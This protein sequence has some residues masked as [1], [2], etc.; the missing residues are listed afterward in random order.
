MFIYLTMIAL[1]AVAILSVRAFQ[2]SNRNMDHS[3]LD[4]P[5]EVRAEIRAEP[6]G[7]KSAIWLID[8]ILP[9]EFYSKEN[10]ER[11]FRYFS[12]KHPDIKE[13]INL[14]VY[15]DVKNYEKRNESIGP[16]IVEPDLLPDNLSVKS[17]SDRTNRSIQY[18]AN[19]N[20]EGPGGLGGNFEWYMY[21]P[22]LNNPDE[23]KRIVLK[24]RDP[25]ANKKVI[26]S[27]Q[28]GNTAFIIYITSY[29]LEGVEPCGIYFTFE[30]VLNSSDRREIMTFRSNERVAI[31]RDQVRFIN[32]R[33][34]YVFMGWM[35][36]VTTDSGR[37]WSVWDADRDLPNWQ[38]CNY[39]LIQD[40]QIAPDGTGT[41][42]LNPIPGRAGEVSELYTKDYGRHWDVQ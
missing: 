41:M 29:E 19:F 20:R 38:C 11:L 24:G 37:N 36:A 6:L 3:P 39:G 30:A 9:K 2:R 27:W 21:S 33:I 34:G 15:T 16:L 14:K 1:A 13:R 4:F 25:Y 28:I 12:N 35:Y 26:D 18:D 7:P 5:F 31:P 8:V 17:T 32:D 10:L 23:T 22:D 40:V 42:K